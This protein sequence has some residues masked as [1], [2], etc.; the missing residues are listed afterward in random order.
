M[1]GSVGLAEGYL[2]RVATRLDNEPPLF[3]AALVAAVLGHDS[4]F[5]GALLPLDAAL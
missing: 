2:D 3:R 4:A 1:G 5:L